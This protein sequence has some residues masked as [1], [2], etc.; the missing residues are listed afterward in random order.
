MPEEKTRS[1]STRSALEDMLKAASR[2]LSKALRIAGEGRTIM[3]EE[4][5]E[6]ASAAV[7]SMTTRLGARRDI[8][9]C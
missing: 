3:G 8:H 6:K 2:Q 1:C 4:A 7:D 5:V 9:H